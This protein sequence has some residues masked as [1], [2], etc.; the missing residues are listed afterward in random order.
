MVEPMLRSSAVRHRGLSRSTSIARSSRFGSGLCRGIV[1]LSLVADAARLV[2]DLS[3][4][5]RIATGFS[6]GRD[7]VLFRGGDPG[8]IDLEQLEASLNRL[9]RPTRPN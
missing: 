5:E 2:G 4:G 1:G 6:W 3:V 9:P 7:R 8:A